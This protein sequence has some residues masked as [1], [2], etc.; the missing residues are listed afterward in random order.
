V[1]AAIA[2]LALALCLLATAPASADPPIELRPIVITRRT[3]AVFVQLVRTRPET[4]A[5]DLRRSFTRE[6]VRS[7]RAEPPF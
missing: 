6:V 1:R 3:P 2:L 4:R 7:V 5:E